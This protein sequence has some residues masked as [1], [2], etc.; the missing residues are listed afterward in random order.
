MEAAFGK[1][2]FVRGVLDEK[3]LPVVY[4]DVR[5]RNVIGIVNAREAGGQGRIDER[6]SARVAHRIVRVRD[7]W[8]RQGVGCAIGLPRSVI[9]EPRGNGGVDRVAHSSRG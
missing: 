2:C 6:V 5:D 9:D 4:V 1:S 3:S 7:G 8:I